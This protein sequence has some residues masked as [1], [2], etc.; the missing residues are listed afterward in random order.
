MKRVKVGVDGLD[1]LTQ[2][3]LPLDTVT[4][5]SGPAGS[6]KSLLSMQFAY[7]GAA[8]AGESVLYITL[9]ESTESILRAMANYGM[10]PEKI[11]GPGKLKIMDLG[12]LRQE[13]STQD[14]EWGMAAME[15][16]LKEGATHLVNTDWLTDESQVE[17]ELAEGMVGFRTLEAVVN[18]FI[19]KDD[20]K[21]LVIDSVAAVGLYYET[22]E[23]LRKE[24][25]RFGRFLKEKKLTTMIITEA[26]SAVANQTRYG[27]EHFIADAHIVLGLRNVRG[28][29]KR[30]ITIQKMRF[31]AHDIGVHPFNITE[32][33][34]DINVREYI[35][36]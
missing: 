31:G 12:W 16:I 23:H 35:R 17:K 25:F 27:V 32:K 26:V 22:P 33:G 24:L 8:E 9:E 2:G 3:G 4:L 20:I 28:E 29:F 15:G 21:R 6:G 14:G 30:T 5:V 34:I 11:K 19:K 10:D 36:F 7:C 1:Q 13:M 18:M